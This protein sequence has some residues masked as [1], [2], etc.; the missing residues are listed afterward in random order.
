LDTALTE[1]CGLATECDLDELQQSVA[2]LERERRDEEQ[3]LARLRGI[4]SPLAA[5]IALSTQKLQGLDRT[6]AALED[7]LLESSKLT[8]AAQRNIDEADRYA[9]LVA[10]QNDTLV[11]I[12]ENEGKLVRVRAHRDSAADVVSDLSRKFDAVMRELVPADISGK[13]VL[14][15]L[16]MQLKVEL[17]GERSTAAIDSWKVVAFDLAALVIGKFLLARRFF[18]ICL[19][20]GLLSRSTM[21]NY[22]G[23][24]TALAAVFLIPA[25]AIFH[26]EK[27]VFSL[28]LGIVLLLPLARIGLTLIVVNVSR[29]R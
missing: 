25:V 13:V 2:R 20:R 10:E 5:D 17:G 21:L 11:S 15:G 6:V 26:W 22:L 19:K 9:A 1:G 18:R 3:E 12:Q 28:A 7:A 23:V 29:H 27:W 4:Q 24:W 16:G 14:D 8:R